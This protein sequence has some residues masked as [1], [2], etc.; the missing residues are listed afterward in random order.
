[1]S[2]ASQL[3]VAFIVFGVVAAVAIGILVA[4][5]SNS[6]DCTDATAHGEHSSSSM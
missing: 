5:M 6:S 4:F 3:V 1:M 2:F